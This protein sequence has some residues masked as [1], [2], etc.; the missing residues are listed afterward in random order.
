MVGSVVVL[1]LASF[2]ISWRMTGAEDPARAPKEQRRILHEIVRDLGLQNVQ[3]R[4]LEDSRWKL[5]GLVPALKDKERLR[6]KLQQTEIPCV[7]NVLS[8]EGERRSVEQILT[9]HPSGLQF[10]VEDGGS[11]VLSGYVRV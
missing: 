9:S 8:L 10:K 2:L 7:L 5:S 11:L 1:L 4:Q 3:I 6:E